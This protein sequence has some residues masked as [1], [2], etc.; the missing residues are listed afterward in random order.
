MRSPIYAMLK[1]W[2]SV[3]LVGVPA[4]SSIF[5]KLW[6]HAGGLNAATDAAQVA[7]VLNVT[8]AIPA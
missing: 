5:T 6:R 8:P 3:Y 4:V 1:G 7:Y 2:V